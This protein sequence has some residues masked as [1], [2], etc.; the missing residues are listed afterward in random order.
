MKNNILVVDDDAIVC[1]ILEVGLS[2]TF[3]VTT[4]TNSIEA[5][6]LIKENYYS[7]IIT[8][9]SMPDVN[10]FELI[11]WL[12]YNVKKSRVIVITSL[13][14]KDIKK[15]VLS[16]GAIQ[17][18]PKP[19][20]VKD[21]KEFILD[22]ID[23]VLDYINSGFEGTINNIEIN[24]L[25]QSYL[26][27]GKNLVLNIKDNKSNINGNIYIEN[28]QII[29]IECGIEKNEKALAKLMLINDGIFS[30]N[31]I[32]NQ[33]DKEIDIPYQALCMQAAYIADTE[34]ESIN[35]SIKSV[36]LILSDVNERLKLILQKALSMQNFYLDIFTDTVD[37][38]S[39]I[40]FTKFDLIITD[41]NFIEKIVE[42]KNKHDKFDISLINSDIEKNNILEL[43]F[44]RFDLPNLL[45]YLKEHKNVSLSGFLKKI[46]FFDLLQLVSSSFQTKIFEIKNFKE[47]LSGKIF[48]KKGILIH[49]EYNNLTGEEAIYEI[50]SVKKGIFIE[51][52]WSEPDEYSVSQKSLNSILIRYIQDT[53]PVNNE[54]FD[55]DEET[56]LSIE[57]KINS[58][59]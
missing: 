13:D 58:I 47:K 36:A 19:V 48:F 4:S 49:C 45:S 17:F 11:V 7:F 5:I 52:T 32:I 24:E 51:K 44:T 14:T 39:I 34:L 30:E 12:K 23:S 46:K 26:F 25:L 59:L 54:G 3:N 31:I 57:K 40:K 28:E 18:F 29:K 15:L 8:D 2:D 55:F 41:D 50:I 43:K 9:F 21:I 22:Y 10:G 6:K 20:K 37:L 42:I 38:E 56:L 27:Q 35:K 1:L 16:I 53:K 33:I